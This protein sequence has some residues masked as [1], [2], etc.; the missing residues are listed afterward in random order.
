MPFSA[1][2][3]LSAASLNGG[4]A[5]HEQINVVAAYASTANQAGRGTAAN[6]VLIAAMVTSGLAA[7]TYYAYACSVMLALRRV[8]D[9]TF[10]EVLQKINVAIQNPVFFLAFFGA[11][12]LTA[13]AVWQQRGST[14]GGALGWTIAALVLYSVSLLITMA[15]NV[16]LNNEL[17]AAGDPATIADPAAVRERFEHVWNSWNVARTLAAT[18][19]LVCL[20]GALR[21]R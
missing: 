13:I 4:M 2:D 11:L 14:L 17:A 1:M 6:V 10:I 7:G 9:R 15:A 8:G 5:P 16:P 18:A 19:A 12:V 20:G 3:G 21:C